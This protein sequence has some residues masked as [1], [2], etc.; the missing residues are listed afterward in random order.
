MDNNEYDYKKIGVF[1]LVIV[2]LLAIIFG[3]SYYF[4]RKYQA[5][6][7]RISNPTLAAEQETKDLVNQISKHF[8]LPADEIPTVAVISD[9]SKL[10]N[11]AFFAKAKNGDKILVYANAKKA[12]L[13]DPAAD[14]ILDVAPINFSSQSASISPSPEVAGLKTEVTPAVSATPTHTSFP[15][16]STPTPTGKPK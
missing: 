1:V 8:D 16:T 14:K 5:A 6:Q 12:I 10:Q 4:Y 9:T 15:T 2:V 7:L 13:Y 3:P 11:Q